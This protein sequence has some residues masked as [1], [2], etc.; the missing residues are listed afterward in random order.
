MDISLIE[1][2]LPPN[3]C[4]Y[5][6]NSSAY[7]Q[8]ETYKI[9]TS[10]NQ[11]LVA[12]NSR[13]SLS[14]NAM[15]FRLIYD[16]ND[17][18]PFNNGFGLY[19]DG[20]GYLVRN[21]RNLEFQHHLPGNILDCQWR[22]IS[23]SAS[24]P[25]TGYL[26]IIQDRG[27]QIDD[28]DIYH[29]LQN[30]LSISTVEYSRLEVDMIEIKSTLSQMKAAAMLVSDQEKNQVGREVASSSTCSLPEE[31]GSYCPYG[32]GCLKQNISNN[33]HGTI[34]S[35][36]NR[37]D[38][39]KEQALSVVQRKLDELTR[40][41]ML[42]E[43]KKVRLIGLIKDINRINGLTSLYINET[44]AENTRLGN[45][46]RELSTYGLNGQ[47]FKSLCQTSINI[48][49]NERRKENTNLEREV[50]ND[51]REVTKLNIQSHV[52]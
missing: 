47:T 28:I 34:V 14:N 2:V 11:Y 4:A 19:I 1:N 9:K 36:A 27:G 29:Y 22:F 24:Q 7:S 45:A 17:D 51:K 31:V 44:V 42:L 46:N 52:G 30:D 48:N 5:K 13:L 38:D 41:K 20:I 40:E 32:Q 43:T 33:M 15:N 12:S 3:A 35:T 16:Y 23:K 18:I 50:S 25:T 49:I 26:C 6:F 10:S 21:G 39:R 37:I 8:P